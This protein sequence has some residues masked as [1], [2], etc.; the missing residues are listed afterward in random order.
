MENAEPL[1]KNFF[2]HQQHESGAESVESKEVRMGRRTEDGHKE[3]KEGCLY[4]RVLDQAKAL[5]S[6]F[7]ERLYFSLFV[8]LFH[9]KKSG[10]MENSYF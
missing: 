5:V 4:S 1:V 8:P 6:L 7:I 3:G 10:P 9:C 2:G